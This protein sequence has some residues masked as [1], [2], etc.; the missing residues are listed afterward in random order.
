MLALY[1]LGVTPKRSLP[2]VTLARRLMT[3]GLEPSPQLRQLEEAILRHDPSLGAPQRAADAADVN[4]EASRTAGL[5]SSRPS[6]LLGRE[7]E[8]AL[9]DGLLA[10]AASGI[11]ETLVSLVERRASVR[12]RSWSTLPVMPSPPGCGLSVRWERSRT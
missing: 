4:A 12:Q 10:Q 11:N 2:T 9:F 1:R 8:K 5:S 7:S 6:S 3:I